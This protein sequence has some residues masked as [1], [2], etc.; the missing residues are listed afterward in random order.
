MTYVT[1]PTVRYHPAV[2]AQKARRSSC[3]PAGRFTLGLGTGENL[4]E[5]VVGQ[6]WPAL[7]QR[8]AM[9]DEAIWIIRALQTGELVD[10]WGEYFQVDSA[11]IWDLPDD[12]VEIAVAVAGERAVETLAPLADHLIA[13]EPLSEVVQKWNED[14]RGTHD[15]LSRP[16]HRPDPDLLGPGRGG[17]HR[18]GTRPVPLVRGRV[19]GQRGPADDGG[20]RRGDPVRTPRGRRRQHPLRTRPRRRRGGGP[21]LLGGRL[22]RRSPRPGRRRHPGE[23]PGRSGRTAAREAPG[24][25][26]LTRSDQP[27]DWS[28]PPAGS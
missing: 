3:S 18:P 23:V 9:L 10:H 20:L 6:G 8:Q 16:R 13:V 25:R 14:R 19:V 11:R 26:S 12:P 1:C 17:G 27:A 21:A 5:H 22:H 28:R 2:V 7:K 24:G 15:R 4:N